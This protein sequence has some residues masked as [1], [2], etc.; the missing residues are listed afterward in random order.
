MRKKSIFLALI[1][2]ITLV[3]LGACGL[4]DDGTQPDEE[5]QV[6]EQ[7]PG[8]RDEEDG[9]DLDDEVG[10]VV[11]Q[12]G[13]DEQQ[14]DFPEE[15]DYKSTSPFTGLPLKNE[16]FNR[17]VAV[18][19]ENSPAARPQSGLDEAE[20]IYEFMAEGGITRFLAVFWPDV[21]EK[22]GPIRSAR[23]FLI[24]TAAAYDS[25][26]LHA[27]ASP[28]G[29]EMLSEQDIMHLDQ[30]YQSKYFWR[31][32]KR[33]APHNLY[34]GK[35]ALSSYLSDLEELEYPEQF[36]F[37]TASVISDF[38]KA[39]NIVIDY[40]GDYEVLYRYDN[41]NNN[42]HRFLDN[43]DNPHQSENG[44]NLI[45]KNIIVQYVKT[46][47]KDQEGRL[48]VDLDSGGKIELFRDGIVVEGR[49][50]KNSDY[51]IEYYNND[52]D[53]IQIN[54][55]QTWIQVVPSNTEISY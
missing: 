47:V 16:Y 31:S 54:P 39:E 50:E 19:I 9:I 15:S 42:Y 52:G 40:W 37:L 43:F 22:I 23:P 55:G 46:D 11:D 38:V 24:E 44:K 18:S 48:E 21:P 29:F 30:I 49:W 4:Q 45:A 7:R 5:S 20:I 3:F 53:N 36:H 10:D 17:A 26:F 34:S 35:P 33:P 8:T 28:D 12:Y 1:L 13:S 25:L 51:K 27:G 6:E 14:F 32:S 41:L 2:I